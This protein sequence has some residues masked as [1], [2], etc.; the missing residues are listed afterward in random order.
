MQSFLISIVVCS[1][2]LPHSSSISKEGVS[3]VLLTYI[4]AGADISEF[5]SNI[6]ED[7]VKTDAQLVNGIISI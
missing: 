5:F 4:A 7:T 3:A 6:N 1:W 2:L